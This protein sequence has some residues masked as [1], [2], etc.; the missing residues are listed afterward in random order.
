MKNEL[1][2]KIE[3]NIGT[4]ILNRTNRRNAITFDMYKKIKSIFKIAG[5]SQ[6]K[7]HLK[8]III[9]GSGDTAFS[10]GTDISEFKEFKTS[11]EAIQYE[12]MNES[13]FQ[14]IENSEIPSIAAL[15]GYVTG[16]GA[17]IASACTLRIGS[18][19]I[20]VGIPIARTL[21]NFVSMSALRRLTNIIG[22]ERLKH[23]L[24]TSQLF[25]AS[26]AL[27]SGFK[28]ELH[29]NKETILLRAEELARNISSFAPLT[30]KATREGIKRLR[31]SQQL[32]ID[33]DLIEM[34]YQ[35][36]DFKEGMNAFFEKRK[37]NFKG[38]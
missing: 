2:F 22:S 14:S 15:H 13:V 3:N 38:N 12:K 37:A 19:D 23:M 7:N 31:D 30:I 4:I 16:G 9:Y 18:K 33:K 17:G 29:Q 5:T 32:P 36:N 34:C 24:I 11:K 10:S 35:S 8:V 28:T 1:I 6:D 27:N 26:E 21:G 20:K 25:N